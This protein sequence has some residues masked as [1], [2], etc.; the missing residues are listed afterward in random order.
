MILHWFSIDSILSPFTNIHYS[1]KPQSTVSS[2]VW[3][4]HELNSARLFPFSYW[5][6]IWTGFRLTARFLKWIYTTGK[7]TCLHHQSFLSS[8][9]IFVCLL[10]RFSHVLFFA[11]PWTVARQAPLSVASPGRNA[12]EGCHALLQRMLPIE[13]LNLGLLC[14]LHWQADSLPLAPPFTCLQIGQFPQSH[15][16]ISISCIWMLNPIISSV[17]FSRSVVSNSLRPHE[18]QHARPPCPSLT[19]GV[20]SNSC[21]LCLWC[22]VSIESHRLWSPSPAFNLSQHHVFS[23]ESVLHIRWPTY[24]S[25]SFRI[26]P[27][28]EYSVLISFTFM[29]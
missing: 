20:Y 15:I 6:D 4:A 7:E 9:M 29:V 12:I 2:D 13:G 26:S 19:P 14:L 23:S 22:H 28:N 18:L 1:W 5:P 25:F 11:T 27:S 24:W 16:L 8:L 17:Q 10:S 21:P 3:T